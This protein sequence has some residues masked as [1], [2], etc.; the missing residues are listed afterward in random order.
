MQLGQSAPAPSTEASIPNTRNPKPHVPLPGAKNPSPHWDACA[1][2]SSE[3]GHEDAL[4]PMPPPGQRVRL[5]L[6]Q[7][8]VLL[9]CTAAFKP[10]AR[11]EK[12]EPQSEHWFR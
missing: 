1:G 6:T 10:R 7:V 12:A 2:G 11:T 8:L 9:P 3:N 5:D 4:S